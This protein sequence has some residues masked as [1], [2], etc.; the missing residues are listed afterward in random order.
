ML[1]R[2]QKVA[3][4][5]EYFSLEQEAEAPVTILSCGRSMLK[6]AAAA[7]LRLAPCGPLGARL[8][9]LEQGLGK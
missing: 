7:S 3:Y 5:F 8:R 9:L 2:T 1:L 6:D 4:D